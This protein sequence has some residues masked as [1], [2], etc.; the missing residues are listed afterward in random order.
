M[1][2]RDTTPKL[3]LISLDI[4]DVPFGYPERVEFTEVMKQNFAVIDAR[5]PVFSTGSVDYWIDAVNGN[6][7]NAGSEALP[8][9]TIKRA[10]DIIPSHYRHTHSA[11]IYLRSGTY[12]ESFDLSHTFERDS[13]VLLVGVDW[14]IPTLV[15]AASGVLSS[16]FGA[17]G[18]PHTAVIV[19]GTYA[20]NELRCKFF[21]ITSGASSGSYLPIAANVSGNLVDF[22]MPAN[23]TTGGG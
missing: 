5:T 14:S 10:L 12:A 7:A 2:D 8:F 23:Q 21:K 4:A 17:Q 22:G 18:L 20:D 3:G 15:G 1:S 11:S 19:S 9:K 6:D 16:S 13:R